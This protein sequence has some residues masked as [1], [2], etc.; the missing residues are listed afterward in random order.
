MRAHFMSLFT[1]L[2]G[3]T[4]SSFGQL[5][6]PAEFDSIVVVTIDDRRMENFAPD[7]PPGDRIEITGRAR[8]SHRSA[9]EL[10]QRFFDRN[11]YGQ[12]QA[13]TPVHDL[14][15]QYYKEGS[16]AE[17]VSISLWTNNLF[18]TF[19]LHAQRQ[20]ECL[21]DGGNGHCCTKGGISIEFKKWLI[22]LLEG[23][24]LPVQKDEILHF[25]E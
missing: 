23:Y 12:S 1:L 11:S 17:E 19:L 15:F 13:V 14:K 21:C 20:G 16:M 4:F 24:R 22:Q 6:D 3:P 7:T 18:A 2:L 10:R 5:T 25:G 9:T 8:L